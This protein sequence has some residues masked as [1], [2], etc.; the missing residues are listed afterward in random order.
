MIDKD[1]GFNRNVKLDWLN[2]VASFVIETSDSAE[3]RQRL[4]TVLSHDRTGVEAKR[5]TIDILIN[6][7]LKNGEQHP[8]L[9]QFATE[10]FKNTVIPTD[11][12][13]L[14]YGLTILYYKFF[15]DCA[16]VMGKMSRYG[17]LIAT[18]NL[19]KALIAQRGNLGSLERSVERIVSSLRDWEVLIDSDTKYAYI[20]KYREYDSSNI[21]LQSWML[22]CALTAKGVEQLPYEDLIRLPELFPFVINVSVDALRK[23]QWF[24]VY[25]QGAGLIMVGIDE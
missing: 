24:N 17:E 12:L 2:A 9:Y 20:A 4:D 5:K 6:I 23:H 14:H 3:I 16:N 22:K 1:I 7:W 21:D 15:R 11:R 25:R 8:G 10:C 13:W 19:K 18:S